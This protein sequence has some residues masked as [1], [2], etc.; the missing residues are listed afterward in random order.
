M[1]KIRYKVVS[2]VLIVAVAAFMLAPMSAVKASA[3]SGISQTGATATSISLSWVPQAYAIN[4]RVL[5]GTDYNSLA[6]VGGNLPKT[7]TSATIS[8]LTAGTE[9][10]V[11]VVYD[12][13]Y[14]PTS[15]V[16]QYTAGSDY[17]RTMPDK[18]TGVNQTQWWYYIKVLDIGWTKQT[19]ADRYQ[20]EVTDSKGAIKAQGETSYNSNSVSVSKISNNMVYTVRVRAIST[21][22]GVPQVGEWSEVGY[23]FT[24]PHLDEKGCY[25]RVSGGQLQVKFPKV[26]GATGYDIMVSTKAKTGY[27][28]AKSLSSSKNSASISK[29][30]GKKVKNG[31]KYYVYVVAKKK[32][33]DITYTS[34]KLYYWNTKTKSL[35]YF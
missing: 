12:Y 24:Q 10:Y 8:G 14:S 17:L 6:Q 2:M 29:V 22:M 30:A 9:Y 31:K 27:V 1:K 25:V 5:Y 19:G 26:T 32:V 16:T 13:Q 20:Y 15:T 7:A 28:V 35:G 23:C 33:G 34:G 11:K 21:I 4:Y 18:V 3:A